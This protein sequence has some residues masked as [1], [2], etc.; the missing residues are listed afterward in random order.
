MSEELIREFARQALGGVETMKD[1]VDAVQVD[2]AKLQAECS[3]LKE[4][5]DGLQSA[6]D[7]F[8]GTLRKIEQ[9]QAISKA[10]ISA[11]AAG[12]GGVVFGVIEALRQMIGG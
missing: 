5:V 1:K 2:V 4:K 11:V 8:S 12:S 3:S 9:D 7:E 10:R 6:L